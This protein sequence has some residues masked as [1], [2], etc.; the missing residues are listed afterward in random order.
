ELKEDLCRKGH[1]FASRCDTEL[2]VHLWEEYGEGMFAHL[3]GQ[4]AFALYD[5]TRQTVILAR[6]RVGICPLHWARHEGRLWFGSEIK[7]ILSGGGVQ[8]R[9]DP[10][11]L[12]QIFTFFAMPSRRTMFEGISS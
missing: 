3:R 10:R 8:A 7:A 12:D 1:V 4:F 11:G 5:R 9:L 6:D 2:L